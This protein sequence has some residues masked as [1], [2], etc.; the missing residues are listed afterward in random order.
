MKE[1]LTISSLETFTH[2]DSLIQYVP[3]ACGRPF[4]TQDLDNVIEI[5]WAVCDLDIIIRV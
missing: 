5:H 1:G 2:K 3:T 4:E